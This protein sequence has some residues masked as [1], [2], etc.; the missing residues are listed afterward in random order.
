MSALKQQVGGTHYSKHGIQ[1]IE[2][3]V[4]NDLGFVEGNIVKY[5]IRYKDK[6]GKADLE[7]ARHYIDMLIE[8][9]YPEETGPALSNAGLVAYIKRLNEKMLPKD[10]KTRK[11][12]PIAAGCI[13]YFP[14]ALGAVAE[15]SRIGSDQHNPGEPMHWAREKSGDE[16][17]A[18]MRHF[19]ERG[20]IDD[21]GVRHSTKVAW[22]ALAMLQKELEQVA[23]YGPV[24]TEQ[25]II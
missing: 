21:D 13:D 22:R 25:E 6:G 8:M 1:A 20:T 24:R 11:G 17:D 23:K 10:A 18:L 15:L 16:S 2:F 5:I 7:K 19:L 9:R 4:S 14:D 3:I 12:M